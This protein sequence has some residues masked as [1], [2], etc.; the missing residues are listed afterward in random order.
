[1]W[2]P[3]TRNV[4]LLSSLTHHSSAHPVYHDNAEVFCTCEG[5]RE[6]FP[7]Q[8]RNSETVGDLK[9]A[10]WQE[11]PN[12][13]KDFD[14]DQLILYKVEV[15]YVD[16]KN[17]KAAVEEAV[18]GL[19]PL[20]NP[21]LSLSHVFET[22]VPSGTIRVIVQLPSIPPTRPL[23][24]DVRK[25]RREEPEHDLLKDLRSFNRLSPLTNTAPSAVSRPKDIQILQSN[26]GTRA[27]N[28]RPDKDIEITP[29]ALLYGAFGEFLDQ[30]RDQIRDPPVTVQGIDFREL[31]LTVNEFASLMCQHHSDEN[32]RQEKILPA[33]NDIFKCFKPFPLPRIEAA[34]ILGDR[35]SH[36]HANGPA[37]VMETIVEMKNEFGSGN[38][39][40]EIQ[41]IAYYGQ[42]NRH[43][44][45]SGRHKDLYPKFRF[46]ALAISIIGSYIGF[47]ALIYLDRPRFVALTPL[48]STRSPSGDDS[49]RPALFQAFCAACILRYNIHK[50]TSQVLTCLLA[51]SLPQRNL[52]YVQK[53]PRWHND[54]DYDHELEF[55][56]IDV[57]D[58]KLRNE[59]RFLFV[60]EMG[61]KY[62]A[63][64]FTRRYCP[65]LHD[66]CCKQGQ[67]PKLLGYGTVPGG[68]I[69][70]VME[71][72][73]PDNPSAHASNHWTQWN[74]DLLKLMEDFHKAGLVHGDLREANF[75]LP[76]RKVDGPGRMM[77][78]DFDWGGKIGQIFYP[79]WL[80]N[81]Q[82]TE[83]RQSEGL[84]ITVEDDIRI[85]RAA[86]RRLR[87]EEPM[88]VLSG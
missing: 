38:C 61:S 72:V 31:E 1:M 75:I 65:D 63:V 49:A 30:I 83:G 62:V 87:P 27:L 24:D 69:V 80:L 71:L 46:P 77:L 9:K 55:S 73:V 45:E 85:L 12:V 52:P 48:L 17:V 41:L 16:A 28:D 78:T 66:F 68:W 20:E 19:D 39:D 40:P 14:A 56:I 21:C 67:A 11:K 81:E 47:G 35:R 86:L 34:I 58:P 54:S 6:H 88:D 33:L 79:T 8:D 57:L 29:I 70:V 3:L 2:R 59:N 32:E 37:D 26:P 5:N 84:M 23:I 74:R 18:K 51:P 82:L 4:H 44:M 15:I 64:K 36:G 10:I 50:D 7:N 13:L 25:R 76:Y 60:A 53:I 43:N 42:M 22:P